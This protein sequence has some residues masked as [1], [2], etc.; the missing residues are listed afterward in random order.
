MAHSAS[1]PLGHSAAGVGP[2]HRGNNPEA[3]ASPPKDP[4]KVA[5]R[6]LSTRITRQD[7]PV[8]RSCYRWRNQ[9]LPVGEVVCFIAPRR[10]ER[11]CSW[12]EW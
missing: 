4:G 11:W 12:R 9:Y 1:G 6:H 7:V 8:I 2:N 10:T 5:S 3:V